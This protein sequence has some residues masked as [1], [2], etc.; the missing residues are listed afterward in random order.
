[1]IFSR[2]LPRCWVH[3]ESEEYLQALVYIVGLRVPRLAVC[4]EVCELSWVY[5][6][7]MVVAVELCIETS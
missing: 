3:W 2:Y 5:G 6:V 1:M 7:C 4:S